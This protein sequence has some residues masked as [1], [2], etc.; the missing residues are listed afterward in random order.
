MIFAYFGTEV[1]F[2]ALG[3]ELF[4]TSYRSTAS[5]AR[6]IMGA[7]GGGLGLWFEGWAY[8]AAGGHAAA[9]SW[10]LIAALIPPLVI[11]LFVPETSARELE[12]IAPERA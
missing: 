1:L 2:A 5:G 9:I 7:V 6:A 8:T 3:T 10:M 11:L 12:E 4:P